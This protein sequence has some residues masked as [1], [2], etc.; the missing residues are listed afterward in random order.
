MP[1]GPDVVLMERVPMVTMTAHQKLLVWTAAV[2][3]HA[4]PSADP[5][6]P[7]ESSTTNLHAP[8]Q[9]VSI[10]TPQP[11]A[12][13]SVSLRVAVQMATVQ[14]AA[15]V[16]VA[17]AKQSAGTRMIAPRVNGACPACVNCLA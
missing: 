11:I 13:V 2:S 6:L 16:W 7:A 1:T 12:D 3:T 9:P 5:T 10:P 8:A 17:N 14:R 15:L 4:I